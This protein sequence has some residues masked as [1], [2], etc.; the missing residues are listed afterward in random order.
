VEGVKAP[1][2]NAVQLNAKYVVRHFIKS[3]THGF[4]THLQNL[5]D[6]ISFKF[7]IFTQSF[8]FE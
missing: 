5:S 1:R 7:L 3:Y 6:K 8:I 4:A 2:V